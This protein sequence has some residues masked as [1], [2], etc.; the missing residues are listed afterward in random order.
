MNGQ[1]IV[2]E[3]RANSFYVSPSS[4]K[5]VVSQRETKTVK[6]SLYPNANPSIVFDH[7]TP[8]NPTPI[9]DKTQIKFKDKQFPV[10]N[11]NVIFY[12]TKNIVLNSASC[13]SLVLVQP[14]NII[15]PTG[16]AGAIEKISLVS[17]K[18]NFMEFKIIFKNTQI[19]VT[20]VENIPEG[21]VYEN[22]YLKG[23]PE[24]SGTYDVIFNLTDNTKVTY[25]I[26]I[27]TLQRLY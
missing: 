11:Y 17:Q 4:N 21:M 16:G 2:V 3:R 26:T 8:S 27:P 6:T 14:Q 7:R 20:T 13:V 1:V 5:V 18:S 12:K 10:F 23:V 24:K 9:I 15:P 25:T 22:G 19:D